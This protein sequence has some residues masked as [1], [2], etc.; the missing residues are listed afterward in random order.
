MQVDELLKKISKATGLPDALARAGHERPIRVP[1]RRTLP[2]SVQIFQPN[3]CGFP[4]GRRL[5]CP[6][7]ATT[8]R[9]GA[10]T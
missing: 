3:G 5:A 4:S 1:A 8:G 9:L 7:R 10:F 2:R 6:G